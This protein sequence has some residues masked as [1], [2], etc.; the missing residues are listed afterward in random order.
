MSNTNKKTTKKI[1]TDDTKK[2]ASANENTRPITIRLDKDV[3]SSFKN[4]ALLN[5]MTQSELIEKFIRDYKATSMGCD[6]MPPTSGS[7]FAV[8]QLLFKT[9]RPNKFIN[10]VGPTIE[11]NGIEKYSDNAYKFV[12]AGPMSDIIFE[13]YDI[14]VRLGDC[15]VANMIFIYEQ[16]SK[17]A[18]KKYIIS[19]TVFIKRGP[20][21]I[22]RN[23]WCRFANDPEEIFA[24]LSYYVSVDQRVGISQVFAKDYKEGCM[25]VFIPR[26]AR[27]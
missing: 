24:K 10:D 6:I 19:E 23:S 25:E 11:F 4:I 21:T 18:L 22:L 8:P 9:D 26:S 20:E 12:P 15:F 17:P 27:K 5:D 7:E 1:L 13:D 2:N 14:D 16:T 3:A